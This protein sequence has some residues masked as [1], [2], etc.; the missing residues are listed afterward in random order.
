MGQ[1]RWRM[2]VEQHWSHSHLQ[3]MPRSNGG[4]TSLRD[5]FI[6]NDANDWPKFI[7]LPAKLLLLHGSCFS[8]A[9]T[10]APHVP[11]KHTHAS[12]HA[13]ATETTYE[14]CVGCAICCLAWERPTSYLP[15]SLHC[16][17]LPIHAYSHNLH[18]THT[19]QRKYL[20]IYLLEVRQFSSF[21][22]FLW[23][24]VRWT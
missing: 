7:F 4:H 2:A 6:A 11:V 20:S 10:D 21:L 17:A 19:H 22:F 1:P 15:G 24:P 12:A 5:K 18:Y 8:S 13:S 14:I 9:H 3:E 16:L 23:V